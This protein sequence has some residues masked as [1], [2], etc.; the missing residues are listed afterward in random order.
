MYPASEY[1]AF[2]KA[3]YPSKQ[4]VKTAG[5]Y[6]LLEVIIKEFAWIFSEHSPLPPFIC[7]GDY[8]ERLVMVLVS[9]KVKGGQNP[10]LCVTGSLWVFTLPGN[11]W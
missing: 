3:H 11:T 9:L 10:L 4:K 5:I 8:S 7:F 2:V 1:V 6:S